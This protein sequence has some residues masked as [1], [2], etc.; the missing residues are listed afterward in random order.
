MDF[1]THTDVPG[2]NTTSGDPG[3][4]Q[5]P[6][7]ST[8]W[9]GYAGQSLGLILAETVEQAREAAAAVVVTYADEEVPILTIRDALE[10]GGVTGMEAYRDKVPKRAV[11]PGEKRGMLKF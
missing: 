10:A 3:S 6:I 8:G 7:F 5:E 2:V 4:T 9:I 11:K 1:I